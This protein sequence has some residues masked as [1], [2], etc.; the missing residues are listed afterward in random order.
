MRDLLDPAIYRMT[1]FAG[2][3]TMQWATMEMPLRRCHHPNEQLECRV[4]GIV[5]RCAARV[6]ARYVVQNMCRASSYATPEPGGGGHCQS[7]GWQSFVVS[8]TSASHDDDHKS[9]GADMIRRRL[10]AR[11]GG[12]AW[13]VCL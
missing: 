8:C 6:L 9:A 13:C 10:N 7:L 5:L 2:Y 4:P 3:G 1:F 11:C 12:A